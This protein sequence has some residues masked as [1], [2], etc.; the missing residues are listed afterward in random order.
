MRVSDLLSSLETVAG[1]AAGLYL[2]WLAWRLWRRAWRAAAVTSRR[3]FVP[4]LLLAVAP[5]VMGVGFVG[6]GGLSIA[7]P[8][9]LHGRMHPPAQSPGAV[10]QIACF[11]ALPVGVALLALATALAAHAARSALAGPPEA[12][13]AG[14]EADD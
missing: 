4:S 2:L 8:F 6:L 3:V 7:Y 10:A 9:D 13:N 14:P 1:I 11:V 5:G 12:S